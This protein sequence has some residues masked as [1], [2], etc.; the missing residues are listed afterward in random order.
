MMTWLRRVV[1]MSIGSWALARAVRRYPRLAIVQRL[2]GVRR[3]RA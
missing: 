2:L 3:L 1:L